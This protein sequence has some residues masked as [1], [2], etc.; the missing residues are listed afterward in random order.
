M[1]CRYSTSLPN[2][3]S[4]NHNS[5]VLHHFYSTTAASETAQGKLVHL[6]VRGDGPPLLLPGCCMEGG[7]NVRLVSCLVVAGCCRWIRL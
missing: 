2:G 6:V 7:S 1:W 4:L 3:Q 5:I